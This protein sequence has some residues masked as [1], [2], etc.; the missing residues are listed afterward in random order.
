MPTTDVYTKDQLIEK[1]ILA[2]DIKDI[3]LPEKSTFYYANSLDFF[4]F[5]ENAPK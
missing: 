3:R 2:K 5:V 1:N 4:N